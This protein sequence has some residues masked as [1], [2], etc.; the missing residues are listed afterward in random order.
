MRGE[1]ETPDGR[2]DVTE[3]R[4]GALAAAPRYDSGHTTPDKHAGPA[5][6]PYLQAQPRG[7]RSLPLRI[8]RCLAKRKSTFSFSFDVVQIFENHCRKMPRRIA[9]HEPKHLIRLG[10][11][12]VGVR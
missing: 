4:R 9:S 1:R 11:H 3:P 6:L 10:F 2:E 7:V 12:Q 5:P 8:W